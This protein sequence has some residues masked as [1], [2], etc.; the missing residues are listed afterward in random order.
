MLLHTKLSETDIHSIVE[1]AKSGEKY[2]TIASSF[3]ITRQHAGDISINKGVRRRGY[4]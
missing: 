4:K 3:N 1:R 2:K